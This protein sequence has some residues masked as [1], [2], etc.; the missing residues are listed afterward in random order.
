MRWSDPERRSAPSSPPRSACP[1]STRSRRSPEF[2]YSDT[3][4]QTTAA[5]EYYY[6]PYMYRGGATKDKCNLEKI[7]LPEK[8]PDKNKPNAFM[9]IGGLLNTPI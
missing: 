1:T 4:P 9:G 3:A 5:R 7:F 6:I 8:C 2:H